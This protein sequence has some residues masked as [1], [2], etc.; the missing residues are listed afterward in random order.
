MLDEDIAIFFFWKKLNA[1]LDIR[2]RVKDEHNAS[3]EGNFSVNLLEFKDMIH[4]SI[5]YLT[6]LPH[7]N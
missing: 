1:S 6:N 3:V 7:N 4:T 5:Q 2:V